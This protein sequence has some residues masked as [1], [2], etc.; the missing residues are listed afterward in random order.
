MTRN[1][2]IVMIIN[3]ILVDNMKFKAVD[4]F[5]YLRANINNKN[6]MHP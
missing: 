6:I 4:N 2:P 5:K 1:N 3:V